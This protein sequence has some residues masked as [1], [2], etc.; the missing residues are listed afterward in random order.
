VQKCRLVAELLERVSQLLARRRV[1][2][3][4]EDDV[5]HHLGN[6]PVLTIGDR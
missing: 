1:L 6:P 5:F 4:G 3:V 2:G